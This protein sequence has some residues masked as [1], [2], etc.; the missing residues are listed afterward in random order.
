MGAL[1]APPVLLQ[2]LQSC[3]QWVLLRRACGLLHWEVEAL[4]WKS[5]ETLRRWVGREGDWACE[6]QLCDHAAPVDTEADCLPVLSRE[7]KLPGELRGLRRHLT[8]VQ[9][10]EE[11]DKRLEAEL[12]AHEPS[13]R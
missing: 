13:F 12:A 11:E 1:M 5:G 3:A 8:G 2:P 4:F 7:K 9:N 10:L 6:R